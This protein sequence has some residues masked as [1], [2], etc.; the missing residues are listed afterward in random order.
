MKVKRSDLPESIAAALEPRTFAQERPEE[1][2]RIEVEVDGNNVYV[3]A[4]VQRGRGLADILH[5]PS[6]MECI[7]HQEW[8]WKPALEIIEDEAPTPEREPPEPKRGSYF[9]VSG[10]LAYKSTG[11]DC[12]RY[13]AD[14]EGITMHE[15]YRYLAELPD[16]WTPLSDLIALAAR[17]EELEAGLMSAHVEIM[18][19]DEVRHALEAKVKQQD[20]LLDAANL[21]FSMQPTGAININPKLMWTVLRRVEARRKAREVLE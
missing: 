9:I 4:Y 20:D 13:R 7:A 17:A 18:R 3:S 14:E 21:A 12:W 2:R 5:F 10:R 6:A 8:K 11:K 16:N 19:Q 1:G 15:N